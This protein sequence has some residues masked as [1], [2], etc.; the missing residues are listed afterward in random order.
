MFHVCFNFP[1]SWRIWHRSPFSTKALNVRKLRIL[2]R[3]G[4]ILF[5]IV[6][7]GD[8]SASSCYTMNNVLDGGTYVSRVKSF[9]ATAA[10]REGVL[11]KWNTVVDFLLN[12][13][14]LL[15]SGRHSAVLELLFVNVFNLSVL[16]IWQLK[17]TEK[18]LLDCMER[19]KS[20]GS[21]CSFWLFFGNSW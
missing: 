14:L 8:C 11:W 5:E 15:R 12:A 19:S 1:N 18:E 2:V 4:K 9:P 7:Q 3:E 21:Y 20:L 10:I 17:P 13:N 16:K 6:V